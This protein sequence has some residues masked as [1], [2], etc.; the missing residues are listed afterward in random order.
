[1]RNRR[2]DTASAVALALALHAVLVGL[3]LFAMWWSRQ[4]RPQEAAGGMNADV[5]DVGMLS[6]A[7]QRTLRDRPEPVAAEPLPEPVAVPPEAQPRPQELLPRPDTTDQEAVVDAPTPVKATETTPQDEKHRQE[8]VDLTQ[9]RE[10]QAQAQREQALQDQREQQLAEIRRQRTAAGREARLAQ[11]RLSQLEAAR[12]GSAAEESARADAAASGQG[13]DSG[14][15]GRYA[16]ALQ[17]AI[18]AK[19]TRPD[20]IPSGAPCRL[21][22]R[23]RVGGEVVDVQVGSPCSYD[24]Q[25]RRSI[26]AAVRKA[27]PLPYAGFEP[28]FD[29]TL[30]LNFRAP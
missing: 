26:E 30:I 20:S 6:A 14:L 2:S 8:Q 24:E 23:Q 3:M 12:S 4:A 21:I 13:S 11:E 29:R 15:R 17:E 5:V 28:V 19:W 9:Q 10:R 22:I 7:M 16:A 27:Q 1:M 18:R 25:G